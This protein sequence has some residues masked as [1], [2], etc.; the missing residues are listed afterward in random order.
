MIDILIDK[1][2]MKVEV[3]V[4]D[5]VVKI[6]ELDKDSFKDYMVELSNDLMLEALRLTARKMKP[7]SYLFKGVKV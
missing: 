6:E 1:E 3:I 2:S 7:K 4:N 5:E